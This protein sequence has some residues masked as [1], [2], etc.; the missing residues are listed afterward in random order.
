METFQFNDIPTHI[1]D[2]FRDRFKHYPTII[3]VDPNYIKSDLD[4]VFKK[5]NVFWLT[6]E[7][8]SE[9]DINVK[10]K[11][12]EYDP[13]GIYVYI[14]SDNTVFILTTM[15]RKNVSD[16]MVNSLKHK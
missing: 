6:S 2:K 7:I 15:D 1:I 13:S 12:L 10:Q 8:T 16:F 4:K 9:G 3:K 5:S 14:N 11:A